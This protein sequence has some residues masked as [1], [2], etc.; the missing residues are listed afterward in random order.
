MDDDGR[1][2]YGRP[3]RAN[4]AENK[5]E[6]CSPLDPSRRARP[7]LSTGTRDERRER[8]GSIDP[9]SSI[10]ITGDTVFSHS[11]SFANDSND[12]AHDDGRRTG[13]TT[14]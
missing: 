3:R 6:T 2:T 8:S 5:E 9:R 7:R 11:I 12:P 10:D 13:Y 14:S 1:R 4:P